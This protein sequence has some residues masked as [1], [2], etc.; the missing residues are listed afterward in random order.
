MTRASPMRAAAH[1]A[2]RSGR[3]LE[4]AAPPP[5]ARVASSG[6]PPAP[7]E[8]SDKPDD[9]H[10]PD[11]L[12]TAAPQTAQTDPFGAQAPSPF[13]PGALF[14]SGAS[15]TRAADAGAAP[16]ASAPAAAP[17]PS[18]PPVKEIDVD[19]SPGGLEDVSMTMRLSGDKLSVVIRA[20]SSQ[21]LGAIEGARDAIADRQ[22]AIGQPLDSLIVKQ[23]G[24][25]NGNANGNAAS[26]DDGAAG[27][28]WR[29]AQGSGERGGSNDASLSR[30]G[31]GRDRGF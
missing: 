25:S 1:D 11:S 7:A 27:E 23:T 17:T 26:A 3:K 18:A 31:A 15:T 5:A 2:Q 29:S 8:A 6:A 20:A 19:L 13:A 28:T 9:S 24:V 10:Q 30:R 21:T 22:A 12:A 16:R 14:E 4:A